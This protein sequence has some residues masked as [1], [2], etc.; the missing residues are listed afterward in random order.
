MAL[1]KIFALLINLSV[2]AADN[3]LFEAGVFGGTGA[4][5]TR[6]DGHTWAVG[7][8]AGLRWD[9]VS[10]DG[11][12]LV[13]GSGEERTIQ[14][15]ADGGIGFF[16]LHEFLVRKSD[17]KRWTRE[18]DDFRYMT[19][20]GP[21]WMDLPASLGKITASVGV[22][23]WSRFRRYGGYVGGAHLLR[24]LRLEN[25]VRVAWYA[26]PKDPYD[27]KWRAGWIGSEKFRVDLFKF[28]HAAF[29]PE[30][31]AQLEELPVG[32]EWM[33]TAGFSGRFR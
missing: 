16:R 32:A 25:E 5:D 26:F 18:M 3:P 8:E 2:Y 30:I 10:A 31:R 33:A 1:F 4:E 29:G 19:G 20:L 17:L 23:G 24:F 21:H 28:S 12:F 6:S 9:I 13:L 22:I 15:R 14:V 27:P 7:V 11:E